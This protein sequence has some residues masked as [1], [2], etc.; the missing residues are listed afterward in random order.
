[1]NYILEKTFNSIE[2][3]RLN[4]LG[5]LHNISPERLNNQ[6]EGKWSINQVIAHLVTAE[7]LS[8]MY[9]AKKIQGIND[10]ENTGLIEDLKMVALIIS[11][12]LPFKFKAPKVVVENTS[13]STDLDHLEKEWEEVR[14]SLKHLL[15]KIE[16]HQIKRKIYKHVRAGKLNIHQALIFF[17]EHTIHHQPQIKRLVNLPM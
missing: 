5:S 2:F 4:L 7:K 14:N 6:P 16:D 17:R 8:V 12:R 11:Q 9:L 3:Q 10:T 15:D 1:M 13:A